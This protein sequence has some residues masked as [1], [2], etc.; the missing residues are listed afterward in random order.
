MKFSCHDRS[1]LSH[2]PV[3][4]SSRANVAVRFPAPTRFQVA[5]G[6]TPRSGDLDG[7]KSGK[8]KARLVVHWFAAVLAFCPLV[9]EASADEVTLYDF[10][11]P[12]SRRNWQVVNDSVMGGV[13][14]S[15]FIEGDGGAVFRGVV[16]LENNGGFASI[17]TVP[18]QYGL[19]DQDHFV[20]R[21]KGDGQ[22]YKFSA[23]MASDE[24]A[25]RVPSYQCTFETEPGRWKE[26]TLPFADFEPRFRGRLVRE[27]PPL[28]AKQIVSVG[29]M[30][31]D[32][33]AGPFSLEVSTV[34]AISGSGEPKVEAAA[35]EWPQ[36]RGP[37]RDGHIIGTSWP[38]SL[39][40][41]HLRRSWRI[42]LGPSYSGPI[43][44]EDL[45]FT[46][47][48]VDREREIVR[49]L[50]R[51]TGS[52][53]W[54]QEWSGAMKVPFFAA[55]NGSW[56]RSTPAFDGE[57]LYVA[58]MRDVLV[59]L[60]AETGEERWRVDFVEKMKTQLPSFGLVCSPLVDGNAVYLQAGGAFVKL[61]K[62]SGE[63]LWRTL[64][65]GGGMNGGAFSSPVIAE[66]C[67]QRQIVVQTRE[68]LHGVGMQNGK[69]L[70]SQP[71]KAFRG[72]NILTPTIHGNDV[73]TSTYGGK[74]T[75]FGLVRD[76]NAF[77]P[78][79]RASQ[80]SQGYMSS[81][82][83]VNGIAYHLTKAQRAMAME[84]STGRELWTSS[85]RFGKY[86]SWIAN[87]D[88]ILGLD[89]KGL[90]YLIQA[91]PESFEL[92]DEREI[93]ESE[94]WAHLAAA[95]D[96]LFVRELDG[97]VAWQWK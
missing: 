6:S 64:I 80:K 22:R 36:W 16:S 57:S 25:W 93:S 83:I 46:T 84:L 27:A 68:A 87:G 88:R 85:K 53:I 73:F 74:T 89:Q 66:I 96:Q 81:P 12:D 2:A 10:S 42:E 67:N 14:T 97:L 15:A 28:E 38:P 26:I 33:Q 29:L 52:E 9:L 23:R 60:D 24:T 49:A 4:P 90:L 44:S 3:K 45:V 72:M 75:V 31:S 7:K 82:V 79:V 5:I 62:Q 41:E 58:G 95:G 20:L 13:S 39:A 17:R 40:T 71:V 61:D 18:G 32:K 30:I 78:S 54:K 1:R 76:G 43:V 63:I 91:N 56:I 34:R 11:D 92:I 51:E 19:T 65:D 47:E 69:T 86:V 77:T 70:W 48:T 8:S 59:C 35:S 55:S 37:N 94:T 50:D 21:I